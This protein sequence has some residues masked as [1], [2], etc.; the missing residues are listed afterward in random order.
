MSE[1]MSEL[2]MTH[3]MRAAWETYKETDAFANARK[4]AVDRDAAMT[5]SGRLG[6]VEG[7][8]W[9]AFYRGWEAAMTAAVQS[10]VKKVL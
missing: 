9:S 8:L 7:A 10:V 2:P 6:Y 1:A 4:W 3:P 5:V